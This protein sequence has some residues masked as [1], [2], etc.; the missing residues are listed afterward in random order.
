[1]CCKG[2]NLWRLGAS[3][4]PPSATAECSFISLLCYD[5]LSGSG[6]GFSTTCWFIKTGFSMFSMSSICMLVSLPSFGGRGLIV[7]RWRPDSTPG[8][9]SFR[10]YTSELFL[11][12]MIQIAIPITATRQT[13]TMLTVDPTFDSTSSSTSSITSSTIISSTVL[14]ATTSGSGIG[15]TYP[16]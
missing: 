6:I 3:R 14:L 5:F 9:S 11:R 4:D 7:F 13:A 10:I 1:M 16:T 12:Q 2:G 8:C 15:I